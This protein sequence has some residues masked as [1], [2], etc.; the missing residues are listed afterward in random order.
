MPSARVFPR[1][2]LSLVGVCV[3]LRGPSPESSQVVLPGA[4]SGRF[5]HFKSRQ[6]HKWAISSPPLVN[7]SDLTEAD[8]RR[9]VRS[10]RAFVRRHVVQWRAF[11][12]SCLARSQV[13]VLVGGV[14]VGSPS[15]NKLLFV[16][17]GGC[18]PW[19]YVKVQER[20][21]SSWRAPLRRYWCQVQ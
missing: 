6:L 1:R 14:L 9:A 3:Q 15:T 20:T 4:Y 5:L 10:I 18:K 2:P 11:R 13:G 12:K 21:T 19:C 8:T 17:P 16:L 7:S